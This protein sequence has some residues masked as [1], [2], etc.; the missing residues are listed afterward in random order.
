[1]SKKNTSI[2]Y[3]ALLILS[4]T[5]R[6]F[7]AL[8]R[9]IQ[10]SRDTVRRFLQPK[11]VVLE[12]A[13]TIAKNI[14]KNSNQLFLA[15]DD[16]L[17]SKM[18]SQNM[19]GTGYFFDSKIGKRIIAY[20][21]ILG[22]ITNGKLTVPIGLGFLFAKELLNKQDFVLDKLDYIKQFYQKAKELFP[23]KKIKIA[24]DGL[25]AAIK[26]LQWAAHNGVDII[27]RM[28][29]NRVVI[30]NGLLCK[31]KDIANLQPKGRQMA[32]VIQVEW[33]GIKLYLIAE[34]RT[35]KNG[36]ETVVYLVSTYK[37]RARQYVKDYKKRWPI[38]K[39][40]RTT[41]QHLGIA[42]CF[43]TELQTQEKHIAA[44]LLAYAITQVKMKNGNFKTPE[45]AIR[46]FKRLKPHTII[47]NQ[48][49]H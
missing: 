37:T 12:L 49:T 44:S 14:F 11:E 36:K 32:R 10:K 8:G 18:F 19:V 22:V 40:F 9:L 3:S 30:Y 4:T 25:F 2:I 27:V 38:E 43:S 46:A 48:T 7:S 28:H 24:A 41:K 5:K 1:M 17:L 39:V 31:I 47:Q 33:H 29:S 16:T 6:S 45:D 21:L 23:N 34:R 42:E 35:S 13:H 26:F 20:R 15:I